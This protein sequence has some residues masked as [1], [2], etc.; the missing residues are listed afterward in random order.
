MK[1]FQV[2]HRVGGHLLLACMLLGLNAGSTLAQE[3]RPPATII[4]LDERFEGACEA[5][6]GQAVL[7]VLVQ[8]LQSTEGRVRAQI[9]SS[10]P[11]EFLEKGMK[12]VRVDMPLEGKDDP[13]L[14]V[15]LPSPGQYALVVLHDK[16][17][18]GKADFFSEGFGFSNNPKLSLGPP[19]AEEVMFFADAGISQH[20][21]ELTY[22]F[23]GDDKKKDKR[24]KLKR[25]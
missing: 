10:D 3:T 13:T 5:T 11:D 18:N 17:S 22:I 12:L 25:R 9:Y 23:G 16:N 14:C 19:D 20:D 4:R 24:R 8:G 7:Q 2:S 6:A 1:K 15:P 21:I